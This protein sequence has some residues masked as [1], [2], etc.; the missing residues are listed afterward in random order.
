V[1][2]RAERAALR[3][4]EQYELSGE[5]LIYLNRLSDYFYL[6]GRTVADRT[7]TEEILWIP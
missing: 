3:A 2:R 6:L 7:A 1:C 4:A 5:A